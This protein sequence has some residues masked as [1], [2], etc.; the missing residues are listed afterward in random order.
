MDEAEAVSR[1]TR[2]NDIRYY[3]MKDRSEDWDGGFLVYLRAKNEKAAMMIKLS[4]SDYDES[5]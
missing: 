4:F 1:L 5:N 3:Q 2:N